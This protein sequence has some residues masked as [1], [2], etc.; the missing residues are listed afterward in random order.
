M[1]IRTIPR[2][3][4]VGLFLV[5][6]ALEAASLVA[7]ATAGFDIFSMLLGSAAFLA[8]LSFAALLGSLICTLA[9][10][11]RR[12]IR[13]SPMVV[14]VCCIVCWPVGLGAAS[15]VAAVAHG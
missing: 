12:D 11:A 8:L 6:A 13:W 9:S 10:V 5:G 15:L 4:G 14:G 1:A 2:V 7:S 3:L